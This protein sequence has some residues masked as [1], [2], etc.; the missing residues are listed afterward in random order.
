[1]GYEGKGL[2]KNA[3][4]MIDPI[5]VEERPNKFGLG[6]VQY[7]GEK[8]TTMK[9]F[10]TTQK[11]IFF[12]SSKPQ[13]CQVCF[14]VDFHCLKPMLQQ[15]MCRNVAYGKHESSDSYQD[16]NIDVSLQEKARTSTM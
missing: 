12:T 5:L 6:Y 13:T 2:G 10:E 1:M 9:A 8:Y 16:M 7:Y 14:Q 11:I 4:G 3:Q 15:D